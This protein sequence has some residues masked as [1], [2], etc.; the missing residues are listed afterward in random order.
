MEWNPET[1]HFL[2]QC[3]LNT[4]SPDHDPRR[5]A[6]AA[7][8]EAANRPN[9]AP[10]V[11]RL[12]AEPSVHD[13]RQSAAVNFKNHLKAHWAPKP[14]DPLQLSE[15]LTIIGKHDF[16]KAWPILLPELVAT[17]DKLSQANDYV[18]VNGVLTA[19]NSLFEKFRYQFK[20]NELLLD[21]KYW[22]DSFA[23]ALLEVFKRN[24]GFIDQ[25]VGSRAVDVSVLKSY[26]ESQR[27]CC[28]IFYSLNFMELPEFFED[29]MDEWM[30]EFNKYLTVK[31][32]LEDSGNDGLALVDE[33]PAAVLWGLLAVASNSS[34]R[35][36]LTVTAIKFLT[37]VSMSVHHTLFARDDIL[38]QICQ[39]I[40]IP[41][42][43][44]R[45]EDEELFEMNY[46]EFIRRDIEG[47]DLDTR[48]RIA[49]ELL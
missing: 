13:L 6:E 46:V 37:T 32:S 8:S 36:K 41:N 30:I 2:S 5:R 35:E 17:L 31:Y 48:R 20:T 44:L 43:M 29:R 12:F 38:Q 7:L 39:S 15:A 11:L 26:V 14:N 18:S 16:P 45:D 25:A 33:L 1:L 28:R 34:S 40:V 19:I 23:K 27:L 24:A 47:S 42:V 9:Y 49:C 22:L 10:A 21:L 3:F 4:L